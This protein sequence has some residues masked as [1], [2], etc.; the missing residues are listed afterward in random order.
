MAGRMKLEIAESVEYLEKSMKQARSASQKER[1]QMLWWVKS[2]QVSEHQDLATRL[3][4][5]PS[6]ITRWLQRYRRD[7][8]RALLEV[9]VPPGAVPK[10][11]GEIRAALEARLESPEGF[12]SYGEIV[13]WLE[14]TFDLKLPYG[15]VY[16]FVREDL[17]AGLKVPR[18]VSVHQ[19]PEAVD[20]FKKTFASP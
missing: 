13:E 2:G 18:P 12:G 3:G 20:T 9:K 8:L 11:K 5:N 1:L 19:H 15:T 7:G 17:K 6:T 16:R 10:I 14:Q 4:R